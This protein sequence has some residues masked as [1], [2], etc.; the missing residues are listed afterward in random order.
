MPGAGP[1]IKPQAHDRQIRFLVG[2]RQLRAG[3]DPPSRCGVVVGFPGG[4]QALRRPKLFGASQ[5]V[6]AAFGRV[7]RDQI[8]E[9]T[10]LIPAGVL[11]DSRIPDPMEVGTAGEESN[12]QPVPALVA[13]VADV[14]GL[15]EIAD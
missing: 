5:R 11:E 8:G 2:F 9:P 7:Q 6:G 12:L 3:L 14:Q 15:V 1:L 4:A 10:I 13:V